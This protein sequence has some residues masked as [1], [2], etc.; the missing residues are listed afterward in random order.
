MRS[1]HSRTGTSRF[2]RVGV[3][4][5]VVFE[6]SI[7]EVAHPVSYVRRHAKRMRI[8]PTAAE[9][10]LCSILGSLKGGVLKGRF[11][12]QHVVSGRWIVDFFFPEIRLA[13]EVDGAIHCTAEQRARDWQ[14][15]RDC[16]R[17]DIT[18]L[19]VTNADVF[20]DRDKLIQKLR[21]GWRM[22]L[23]RENKIIGK[24]HHSPKPT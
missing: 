20:G 1:R 3:I 12:K 17:F 15:E 21:H 14:K 9:R 10:E 5:R 18:L 23:D 11:T 6:P 13:I 19:R 22:A 16:A 4:P 24:V 8:R 7:I 2:T